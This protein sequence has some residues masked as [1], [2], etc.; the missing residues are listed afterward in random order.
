MFG[1]KRKTDSTNV[2]IPQSPSNIFAPSYQSSSNL[3]R[4]TIDR[5]NRDIIDPLDNTVTDQIMSNPAVQNAIQMLV[6][7]RETISSF[8]NPTSS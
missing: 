4:D 2:N 5:T 6:S 7:S 1:R 8:I 3:E